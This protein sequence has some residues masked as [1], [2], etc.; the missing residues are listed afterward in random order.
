[1]QDVYGMF[2]IMASLIGIGIFIFSALIINRILQLLPQAKV[3][4]NWQ[5][6]Y[7][8][9]IIFMAGYVVNIYAVM[10]VNTL[11][12]SIMQS[13]VYVFGAIFVFIV[14]NLSY[15]TY[16]LIIESAE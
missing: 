4:K 10:T 16:K 9:L 6:L 11:V 2:S 14:V 7:G 13:V 3:K 8:L 12:L 15:R 1:M 5:I